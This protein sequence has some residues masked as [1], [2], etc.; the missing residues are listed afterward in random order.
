MA[1]VK[2]REV[3][4][5]IR[6]RELEYCLMDLTDIQIESVID[7]YKEYRNLKELGES[8]SLNEVKEE[9]KRP[10]PPNS[11]TSK[12]IGAFHVDIDCSDALKGLKAVQREAR[13]ATRSLKELEEQQKSIK[14][15]TKTKPCPKCGSENIEVSKLYC[16]GEKYPIQ[17]INKCMKC[18]WTYNE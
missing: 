17:I 8:S 9:P 6:M 7:L 14:T 3:I 5:Y 11:T 16:D 15:E 18:E 13:K 12:S 4:E 2:S 1:G 10:E